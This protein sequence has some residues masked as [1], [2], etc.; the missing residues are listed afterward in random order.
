MLA[1]TCASFHCGSSDAG[2][3]SPAGGDA[4]AGVPD[5]RLQGQPIDTDSGPR[6]L[7]AKSSGCGSPRAASPVDGETQTLQVAGASRSFVLYVPPKYDPQRGYPVVMAVH[8]IGAT[9]ADMASFIQM[10]KYSAGNAI[11]AFPSAVDGSWDVDGEKDLIFF[12]VILANLTSTLCVNEQRVF[13]LGFSYGAYMVNHLGC[14]RPLTVRAIA[15]ADGGFP[16]ATGCGKTAALVY[17][18]TEDDDEVL[19]NGQK[20]RDLWLGFNGCASTSKS[21]TSGGFDGLGC[22]QYD[23]C[24]ATSPVVWCEDKASSPYKH[25]L[26][27]V[28][29]VPIWNWFNAF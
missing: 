7:P 10:Q 29:R 2:A 18:R 13:G 5:A 22:V 23:G 1:L 19:A 21:F 8:G 20:A 11:V 27:D 15:A 16:A 9:G 26:R 12:D 28:Y 6:P 24:S 4:D 14:K 25:D 17:H 3:P